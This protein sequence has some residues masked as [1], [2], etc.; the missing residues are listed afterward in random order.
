MAARK[1][2]KARIEV[3]DGPNPA[4]RLKRPASIEPDENAQRLFDRVAEEVL[5]DER[6]LFDKL[7]PTERDVV[8]RWLSDALVQGGEHNEVHDLLWE[9]DYWKKPVL[10]EEFIHDDYFLGRVGS[11]LDPKWKEDLYYVFAPGSP[12]WE[13]LMCLSGDTAIPLLDGTTHTLA[14]LH[15]RFEKDASPFWVYSVDQTTGEVVPGECTRVTKFAKDDLFRVTF[16]DGSSVRANADHEFVCRDG[17][18]RKLRDLKVGDRLMPFHGGHER[19]VS[20]EPNGR[21]HVYCLT[22][23]GWENFAI[24]TDVEKRRGIFSGNT[25]AIGIGKHCPNDTRIATPTGWTTHGSVRIGDLVVGANGNPTKVTGVFPQ[26][27]QQVYR[28]TFTDGT[29]IEAG[30]P[31]LWA[32]DRLGMRKGQRSWR[33]EIVTTDTLRT[34]KLK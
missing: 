33:R 22:V 10:I 17:V 20:I 5:H 9:L 29:S 32:V 12:V 31:H 2:S 21:E 16:E 15:A 14:E 3:F 8:L 6:T 19:I 18:K 4:R 23:P 26:G 27:R 30:G 34:R 1:L 28:V 11:K 25:G 7:T 13:W 24:A